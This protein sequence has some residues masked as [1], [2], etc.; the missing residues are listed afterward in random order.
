MEMDGWMDG[1]MG[2][3][4]L[5][6]A[7]Y[8]PLFHLISLSIRTHHH[9]HLE[10]AEQLLQ[11]ALL[12]A[13]QKHQPSLS[14]NN[15]NPSSCINPTPPKGSRHPFVLWQWGLRTSYSSVKIKAS[16]DDLNAYC[17][18]AAKSMWTSGGARAGDSTKWRLGS[19]PPPFY[20]FEWFI[21]NLHLRK[22]MEIEGWVCIAVSPYPASFLAR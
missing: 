6:K 22:L 15:N 16:Q 4:S 8:T 5:P 10:V 14:F 20:R 2:E 9:H 1:W 3:T 21:L 13:C 11:Q 18:C 19:L 12:H 7:N 17:C